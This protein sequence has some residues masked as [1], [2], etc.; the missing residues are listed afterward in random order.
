MLRVL[1]S[2][3]VADSGIAIL[4]DAGLDIMYEPDADKAAPVS[5]THLTL[6]TK[7]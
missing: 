1:V 2:D 6:P 7:A 3:P 5:Y 4:K